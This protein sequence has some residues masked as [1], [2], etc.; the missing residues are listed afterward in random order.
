M[1]S[2][3]IKADKKLLWTNSSPT[4]QFAEQT[5]SVDLSGYSS[6]EV[7]Y[8][9][10]T[11]QNAYVTGQFVYAGD[12]TITVT[13]SGSAGY[14]SGG[15]AMMA[16][17]ATLVTSGVHF[18]AASLAAVSSAWDVNNSCLIPYRIYGIK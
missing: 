17:R 9:L 11:N 14:F 6:V 5:V 4:A 15:V 10:F 13:A 12:G 1:A 18:S 2:S 3:V 8:K 16:R 7:V